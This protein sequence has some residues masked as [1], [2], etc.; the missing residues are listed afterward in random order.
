MTKTWFRRLLLSY[1]PV[2]FIVI[3]ILFIL[4]FQTLNELTRREAMKANDFLAQQVV[5]LTD[6]ALRSIEY[7]VVREIL[8]NE[9][10]QRFF[11][12]TSMDV[13][14]NIRAQAVMDDLKFNYPVIDSIYFVRFSDGF[15]F[16]DAPRSAEEF[17]DAPFIR[18]Y[19][20][21]PAGTKWSDARKFQA[22]ADSDPVDVVTMVK[23]VPYNRSERQGY[24][25]VNVSLA[26][27]KETV[28]QMYNPDISLVK[29]LDRQGN[30]LLG[31]Q[32]ASRTEE[33][34]GAGSGTVLSSYVSPYTGWEIASGLHDRNGLKWTL[35]FYYTW[36]VFALIVA[37]LGI[38][39]VVLVTK[40]NYKPIRQLVSLI[41]TY[42][43]KPDHAAGDKNG[44]FSFIRST[45]ESL[46]N[47][48]RLFQKRYR[49]RLIMQRRYHFHQVLEG[50]EQLSELEWMAELSQFHLRVEGK[51]ATAFI[52]EID[53]YDGFAGTYGERDRSLLKFILYSAVHETA[54]LHGAAV[55]A[56]WSTD[57]RLSLILWTAGPDSAQQSAAILE[58]CRRWIGRH[59]SFTITAGQ[60]G[61][62]TTLEETRL[63]YQT[64]GQ[65][66]QFKAVLG[67]NR[68]IA[69]KDTVRPQKEP[70]EWF[71][72][73]Y[74]LSPSLRMADPEWRAHIDLF[75]RQIREAVLPRR[76]IENVMQFFVQHL[77]GEVSEQSKDYRAIWSDI[78]RE[79]QQLA[80]RWDTLDGLQRECVRIF[81]AMTGRIQELRESHRSRALILQIRDFIER[82]FANPEL[83]LDYLSGKF[84]VNPK[85]LSKMFKDEIGENFVDFLIGRRIE[86]AKKML[87]ETEK[88]MQTISSEVGYY[89]Y[90]SFNRAFKNV[91]GVSPRD[92]RKQMCGTNKEVAP[93]GENGVAAEYG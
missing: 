83:S 77:D 73:I 19:A 18:A 61:P 63:S 36:V 51:T 13:L 87:L 66:L 27:L 48:S 34:G 89:N 59:V 20:A 78:R 21:A 35:S 84:Q 74:L 82:H 17:G 71:K 85:Y 80:G 65:C 43:A 49:E 32:P 2:F 92:Y 67:A 22:F 86:Q 6:N 41:E 90:N 7:R 1:L 42:S 50:N 45:L 52:V 46:M 54:K 16:G 33:S 24:F 58:E 9:D 93:A 8:A 81:D 76:E 26:K 29:M 3:T 91:V 47:E 23:S 25:V 79:L 69:A 12:R 70:Q 75:F 62:A 55:W 39:W 15:I 10:V 14:A 64:A 56:E 40:R 28:G 31:A 5:R 53:D 60:G 44:E 37:M 11:S 57:R 30:D 4:F 72:T 38:I 68:L 88:P